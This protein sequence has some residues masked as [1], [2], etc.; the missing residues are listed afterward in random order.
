MPELTYAE[1]IRAALREEMRRD[2]RVFLFGEDIGRY[3]GAFGVTFGLLGVFGEERVRET[4]ISDAA[5]VGAAVGA[6]LGGMRPVAEIMFMDFIGVCFDQ[7]LNQMAKMKYMFGGKA[8]LPITVITAAE[9]VARS[10]A[11][12]ISPR[13]SPFQ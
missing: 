13:C 2:E 3:G 11:N 4:P 8:R 5:I 12:A 1:A 10:R 7:I 6:A 9:C